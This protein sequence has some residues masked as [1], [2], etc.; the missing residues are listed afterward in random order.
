MNSAAR[1]PAIAITMGD[2]AGVG[3]ETIVKAL[4][5]E[6]VYRVCK[7]LLIADASAMEAA[8]EAAGIPL[9]VRPIREPGE[10]RYQHGLLDV[11]DMRNVP[12][13]SVTFGQPNA[14][15]GKAAIQCL[16][17]SVEMASNRVVQAIAAAPVGKDSL[18]PLGLPGATQAEAI[19]YLARSGRWAVMLVCGSLRVAPCTGCMTMRQALA[20]LDR[21]RVLNTVRLTN[22]TLE[23]LGITH[24]RILVASLNPAADANDPA[25]EEERVIIPAIAAAR[26]EGIDVTGPFAAP[27]AFSEA[28]EGRCDAVAA[29]YYDQ[30]EIAVRLVNLRLSPAA[31]A[32]PAVTIVMG[33]PMACAMPAHGPEFEAAGKGTAG[34]D[35]MLLA[36]EIAA[37]L[38]L[39]D[40]DRGLQGP[41]GAA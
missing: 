21:A 27:A 33:L 39:Q 32:L 34:G 15:G 26:D 18:G 29:M 10:A 4:A 17:R 24:A 19:G 41:R 38:A 28:M 8:A 6:S 23:S 22:D 25:E 37:R 12:P 13:D 16:Q 7:P 11:L 1:L 2:P 30:A 9:L 20:K 36:L 35:S 3:P 5:H 40:P 31:G 14:T